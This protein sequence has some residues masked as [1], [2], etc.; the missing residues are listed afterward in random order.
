LTQK[1]ESWF[2][3]HANKTKKSTKTDAKKLV[4]K[5]QT[6]SG[7]TPRLVTA[8]KFYEGHPDYKAKIDEAYKERYGDEWDMSKHVALAKELFREEDEEVQ[9]KIC[10]EAKDSHRSA[11]AAHQDKKNAELFDG[12]EGDI[13][14]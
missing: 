8:H 1:I 10:E 14:A 9:E 12:V 13:D 2:A 7:P 3:F 5:F 4:K 11:L 6:A